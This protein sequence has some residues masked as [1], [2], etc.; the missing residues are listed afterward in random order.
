MSPREETVYW[1]EYVIRHG[2]SALRSPAVDMKW[3]QVELLDVYG[4]I[5]CCVLAVAI[6]TV[7]MVMKLIRISFSFAAYGSKSTRLYTGKK[8]N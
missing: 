8:V 7:Y 6:A 4:F 2:K 1:V 5:A 3:W